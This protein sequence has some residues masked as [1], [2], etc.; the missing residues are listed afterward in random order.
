MKRKISKII[1]FVMIVSMI[2][3]PLVAFASSTGEGETGTE[4]IVDGGTGSEAPVGNLPQDPAE[5]DGETGSQPEGEQGDGTGSQPDGEEGDGTGSD[6][7]DP[8]EES[9]ITGTVS[10][11]VVD[12]DTGKVTIIVTPTEVTNGVKTVEVAT[13]DSSAE[14][15]N[16]DNITWH[17]AINKGDGTY[18]LEFNVADYGYVVGNY[19]VEAYITDNADE[20]VLVGTKTFE[21]EAE[22]EN[23]SDEP[24]KDESTPDAPKEEA[25][26]QQSSSANKDGAIIINPV[27]V[28][29]IDSSAGTA[30]ITISPSVSSEIEKV[31][32][33][34]WSSVNGQDDIIWYVATKQS[35]GTYT[36]DFSVARHGYD[37]GNYTVHV[38]TQNSTG[39]RTGIGATSFTISPS[40]SEIAVDNNTTASV[41]TIELSNAINQNG[42][43]VRAAVWS[44]EGGHDDLRWLDMTLNG[45]KYTLSINI[46]DFKS[47]GG[48]TVHIYR[49][50]N[51]GKAIAVGGSEFNVESKV[52]AQIIVSETD[53]GSGTSKLIVTPGVVT[54]GIKTVLVPTWSEVGGQDDVVW[55]QAVRQGD[56]TYL[57]DFS[58]ANHK[59]SLGDYVSHVYI[60]NSFGQMNGVGS[61]AF[62]IEPQ[63]SEATIQDVS[64]QETNYI[65][66]LSNPINQKGND[67]LVAVWSDTGGQDD[68]RWINMTKNATGHSTTINI[69]D[70]KTLGT[71]YAHVYMIEKNGAMVGQATTSFDVTGTATGSIDIRD[72]N[73]ANGTF[74]ATV[75]LNLESCKS[76]IQS[77]SIPVW[78]KSD[79][80]D[81][82][83]YT[84]TK[85]SENIYTATVDIKN[86]SFSFG[87]YSVHA[88][89]RMNNGIQVGLSAT[90]TT[91]NAKDYV[92]IESIGKGEFKISVQGIS[93]SGVSGVIFP[94]WSDANGQD[95]IVWYEA[96]K[97]ATGFE[98]IIEA[99]KHK[100]IG[101]FTTHM[102][103]VDSSGNRRSI[104]AHYFNMTTSDNVEGRIDAG[105][106]YV[107]SQTGRDLYA[108]YMWT[109]RNISYYTM[110]THP[111]TPD[112]Y[113][114]EQYYALMGFE[115]R[116]GNCFVYA[117]VF[118]Q[119]A[120]ELGYEAQYIEGY[121]E[122]VRGG[123]VRHGFTLIKLD[124][125]WYICDPNQQRVVSVSL[126]M[127]PI[128][129]TRL[130]YLW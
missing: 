125:A 129:N 117:S 97:T 13:W 89:A 22:D 88:Y 85:I 50:D 81:I 73:G 115:K 1:A 103:Y 87:K 126:Y 76:G 127:Q 104:S 95:D 4:V 59:Y 79:Q 35:N 122:S 28:S 11:P 57:V 9:V 130:N 123:Y 23:Q 54:A 111:A 70:F 83:W 113:T 20:K 46:G 27:V 38:Y 124:G 41:R 78:S 84:A 32:V 25:T 43:R 128:N 65:I 58:A 108:A 109:A 94:T 42:N 37:I 71:Y 106:D 44:N 52:E 100:D 107:L 26:Q 7:E 119:L 66:N 29:M 16:P 31:Y 82:K 18:E 17:T 62:R 72:I 51:T 121:V 90:S 75:S 98:A 12:S 69:L 5:G 64:G 3:S 39:I 61:T 14:K 118:T 49:Y 105:V 77:V 10:E 45:G 24:N 91:I 60:E 30:K 110:N 53:A 6:P 112:G 55:Y 36:L 21:I 96:T 114:R 40:K 19:T 120:R 67:V 34:I 2:Q 63:Q 92:Q 74:K 80:S 68:I 116:Y 48:Y 102:Y 47:A 93:S 8:P 86:H 56:G 101:G 15:E 33:P 99:E